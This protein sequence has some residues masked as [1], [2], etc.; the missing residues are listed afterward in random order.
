ME[1]TVIIKTDTLLVEPG[2]GRIK[3]GYNDLSIKSHRP[4]LHTHTFNILP[5]KLVTTSS[6]SRLPR[7][8]SQSVSARL[9]P[10]PP[11]KQRKYARRNPLAFS[12]CPIHTTQPYLPRCLHAT[13]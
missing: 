4:V 3:N 6:F 8:L 2:T 9:R 1:Q 12:Y 10:H 7:C 5:L 11:T 13:Y